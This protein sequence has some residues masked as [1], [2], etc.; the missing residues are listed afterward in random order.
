VDTVS[1]TAIQGM[2]ADVP[3]PCPRSHYPA[4]R[5]RFQEFRL[6]CRGAPSRSSLRRPRASFEPGEVG[7]LVGPPAAPI[8]Q[9]GVPPLWPLVAH[10]RVLDRQSPPGRWTL[11][12]PLGACEKPT[13]VHRG[14]ELWLFLAQES[15]FHSRRAQN[16]AHAAHIEALELPAQR[17]ECGP[18]AL[19]DCRAVRQSDGCQEAVRNALSAIS[20]QPRRWAT[21]CLVLTAN[22]RGQHGESRTSGDPQAGRGGVE[23]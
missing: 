16:P 9:T 6:L 5:A 15:G 11:S 10:P 22:G 17:P 18:R 12:G 8:D 13:I 19:Y 7:V 4:H 1:P 2:I 23:L 21:M 20:T 14:L 3:F